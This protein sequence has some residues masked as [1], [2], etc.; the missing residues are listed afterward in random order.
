MAFSENSSSDVDIED[1]NLAIIWNRNTRMDQTNTP[2]TLW[3]SLVDLTDPEE[4]QGWRE[5]PEVGM[6]Q[7]HFF[8]S[9]IS[10]GRI[11]VD[12]NNSLD[13]AGVVTELSFGE[14]IPVA[15]HGTILNTIAIYNNDHFQSDNL[16]L[17]R[18]ISDFQGESPDAIIYI[19]GG[20]EWGSHTDG[21]YQL[22][23]D[24]AE[25]GIGI[26]QIGDISATE[27]VNIDPEKTS[28]PVMGV[29]NWYRFTTY[30]GSVITDFNLLTEN[31]D[32]DWERGN[33]VYLQ[34][35]QSPGGG[36]PHI[37][38]I[39]EG[40]DDTGRL[41]YERRVDTEGYDAAGTWLDRQPFDGPA[42]VNE[43]DM[44][45]L[46]ITINHGNS[47]HWSIDAKA[48]EIITEDIY[49]PAM[50]AGVHLNT[51]LVV[52][53]DQASN[54]IRL[55]ESVLWQ[56]QFA[57]DVY[58]GSSF[59]IEDEI[60]ADPGDPLPTP[61]G[62]WNSLGEYETDT[63][64]F[65]FD[66]DY[67]VTHNGREYLII[68]AGTRIKAFPPQGGPGEEL[69][70]T[71]PEGTPRNYVPQFA[72]GGYEDMKILLFPEGETESIFENVF[73][74]LAGVREL[75]FR[76]WEHT[77]ERTGR[78]RASADIWAFNEQLRLRSF[79]DLL[80]GGDFDTEAYYVNYLGKQVAGRDG[81]LH[82]T[83]PAENQDEFVD[84]FNNKRQDLLGYDADGKIYNTIS[85]VQTGRRRLGMLGFQPSYLADVD[86][87]HL[88]LQ[89]ITKWIAV[90]DW[91]YPDPSI[92]LRHHGN[93]TIAQEDERVFTTLDTVKV[94]VDF[95]VKGPDIRSSTYDMVLTAEYN[96]TPYEWRKSV[97]R[98]PNVPV[99]TFTFSLREQF[100]VDPSANQDEQ[101]RL[102]LSAEVEP[103]SQ[104]FLEGA[105]SVGLVYRKLQP[106]QFTPP[107]GEFEQELLVNLRSPENDIDGDPVV[108][109][110]FVDV[111]APT[112]ERGTS[113]HEYILRQAGRIRAFSAKE[114]YLH[115][116][117][118]ESDTFVQ[119]Q[120]AVLDISPEQ[121]SAFG[122]A[123]LVQVSS[124]VSPIFYRIDGGETQSIDHTEGAFSVSRG[125]P[126]PGDSSAV[127]V[128]VWVDG[129]DIV[130]GTH[131]E[132]TYYR[133]RLPAVAIS[134][135][136]GDYADEELAIQIQSFASPDSTQIYYATTQPVSEHL[137]EYTGSFFLPL[138]GAVYAQSIVDP[139]VVSENGVGGWLPSP[140]EERQY[141][142][143]V[144]GA[145]DGSAYFDASAD[146]VIDS[147]VV[148]LAARWEGLS[149]PDE[150]VCQFPGSEQTVQVR[151][152]IAWEE[153][154]NMD[155][156]RIVFPVSGFEDILTGF[157]TGEY[158][159]LIGD[160]YIGN[161]SVADSIAP[162]IAQAWYVSGEQLLDGERSEDTLEVRFSEEIS[163][164]LPGRP[165]NEGL[166]YL[167]SSSQP[168]TGEFTY[169]DQPGDST[170]RFLVENL[171]GRM[172][173]H[174]G[175]SIWVRVSAATDVAD[176]AG[177]IQDN[178]ANRRVPMDVEELR[179]N[180]RMD[181]F[182][183][184]D[185]PAF[186]PITS[187]E[188]VGTP[189]D[190]T[191]SAVSL[192]GMIVIDPQVPFTEEQARS[193]DFDGQL[194]IFDEVGN[195]VISTSG[196]QDD[197]NNIAVFPLLYNGR[198]V[199][200]VAWDGTNRN[201]REV[202]TR[203]YKV[204]A[205][206]RWPGVE[207][208]V[209]V[210]GMIPVIK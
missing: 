167:G 89:D 202:H 156:R 36:Y 196:R 6:A 190:G 154:H 110:V 205:V 195:I 57:G 74:S 159:Q 45:D 139:A 134:P 143:V 41:L 203:S 126:Q 103:T 2:Y 21:M 1:L 151:H 81:V 180:V 29:Q 150:I 137:Q 172:Y 146:G 78:L 135:E 133:R 138:D 86:L 122:E 52:G 179:V 189:I 27:A 145:Q 38:R 114:G 182:W 173:P 125:D 171:T 208:P 101:R 140:V 11:P 34:Y 67:T 73:P 175:D 22:L 100:K 69:V 46:D 60:L 97:T 68:S 200:G 43:L 123:L 186:S 170:F 50:R 120:V 107:S 132:R 12:E 72:A 131:E 96:G 197:R 93:T 40:E 209:R 121:G 98:K 88:L 192:G 115:S 142:R 33:E 177:N 193:L 23:L 15:G 13:T 47:G 162:V 55:I 62:G 26:L 155:N 130:I 113:P 80:D 174:R 79:E 25:E 54:S 118:E 147:A 30:S 64:S 102:H 49:G 76:D 56:N 28:F 104:R 158:I 48:V 148:E 35:E 18:L 77:G 136:S 117:E 87:A 160:Q 66:Q 201:G 204:M 198:Y 210:Q 8:I 53:W 185:V 188:D 32:A 141:D 39:Y 181:A 85:V 184:A 7:L 14:G 206:T 3:R 199:L 9:A 183:I 51:E 168:Y 17:D 20:Y 127:Q 16:S 128:E 119:Q 84:L 82:F 44:N 83:R 4:E 129:D 70:S 166:F 42:R 92:H 75:P 58:W 108:G 19:N 71:A 24:A 111:V 124:N 207:A 5:A 144:S 153:P 59:M 176:Y 191:G 194:T 61:V 63:E 31:D 109:D 161:V 90:D 106:P 157:P 169:Y 94:I 164:I 99:D 105:A 165:D 152:D 10:G 112:E 65:R 116:R 178:P 37:Y 187:Y 91:R 149:L 95:T 163:S